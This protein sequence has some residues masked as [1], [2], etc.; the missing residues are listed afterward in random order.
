MTFT[1]QSYRV[2][3]SL[4]CTNK[5]INT[6]RFYTPLHFVPLCVKPSGYAKRYAQ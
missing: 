2:I 4:C 5:C 3:P 1:Y 6:D